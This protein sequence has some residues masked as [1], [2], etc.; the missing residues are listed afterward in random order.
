[1]K[2][3]VGDLLRVILPESNRSTTALVLIYHKSALNVHNQAFVLFESGRR[4]WIILDE[5]VYVI[6]ESAQSQTDAA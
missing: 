2:V 5:N 1:M 4:N 6:G 3:E